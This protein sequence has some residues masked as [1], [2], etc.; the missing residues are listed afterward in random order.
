MKRE[1]GTTYEIRVAGRLDPCWS[2]WFDGLTITYPSD[3]ETHLYGRVA[4]QAALQGL[5]TKL[6]DVGLAVLSVQQVQRRDD[7]NE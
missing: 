5:L 1:A 3:G 6:W 2:D 7:G 4:D